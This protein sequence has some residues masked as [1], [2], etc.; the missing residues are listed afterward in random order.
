MREKERSTRIIFVRHGE[1]DFPLDRLYCNDEIESPPLNA[2]G[3][4]QVEAAA[5]SL[6]DIKIDAIYASPAQRTQM[7][8][9]AIASKCGSKVV[10]CDAFLE[11]RFGEWDGLYFDD[12]EKDYPAEYRAWKV[13]PLNFS[14]AGGETITD[15]LNRVREGVELILAAHSGET[16]VVAAHV[17]SIRVALADALQMPLEGYRQLRIDYAS[18]SAID[19][20]CRQNNIIYMNRV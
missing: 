19:F 7:T 8:A 12:V 18:R 5:I 15:L 16:V 2:A 9:K 6:S 17:G 13:D 11:R 4:M 10:V 3:Q 1:T 20:G 14:P